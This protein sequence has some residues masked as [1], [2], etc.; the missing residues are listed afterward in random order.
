MAG[1]IIDPQNFTQRYLAAKEPNAASMGAEGAVLCHVLYAWALSYGVDHRGELDIP[2][3]GGEPLGVLSV[4]S[5][6]SNEMRREADRQNRFENMRKVVEMA[7]R[8]IDEI[9]IMRKP[10]W[11]GVRVLLLILPLT[12]GIASPVE[13]LAMYETAL[14]QVYAL[15]SY[16]GLGYDGLPAGTS[17]VNG[18]E[19]KDGMTNVQLV[20]VRIYWCTCI[21]CIRRAVLMGRRIRARRH[22]DRAQGWPTTPR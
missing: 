14:N 10:T 12:E 18:G 1:P 11:D 5:P 21:L 22:H 13:R 17:G 20:R 16:G 15:C 7:L 9:G 8:E 4:K 3:G 19:D 2:E 6:G